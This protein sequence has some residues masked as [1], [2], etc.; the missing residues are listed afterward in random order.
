MAV[1][2]Q[3]RPGGT[4]EAGVARLLFGSLTT[5]NLTPEEN[6]FSYSP[7]PDGRRFLMINKPNRPALGPTTGS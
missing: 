6:L 7:Y 3:L 1:S 4:L 2:M 5:S